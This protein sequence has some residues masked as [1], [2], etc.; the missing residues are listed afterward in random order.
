LIEQ[1]A[2]PQ[3]EARPASFRVG[4]YE[5]IRRTALAQREAVQSDDLDRFYNLLQERE[6]LLE[7]AEAVHQELDADDQVKAGGLVRDILR[8]DQDTEQL[9]MGKIDEARLELGS[10]AVGRQAVA[11]YGRSTAQV[12]YST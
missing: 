9:L 2:S 12:T 3:S 4:L 10:M 5:A 11:A 6:K 1:L 7:K 8:V